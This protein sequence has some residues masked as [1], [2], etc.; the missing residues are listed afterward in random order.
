ML[1]YLHCDSEYVAGIDVEYTEPSGAVDVT[2][3]HYSIYDLGRQSITHCLA[4]ENYYLS[5]PG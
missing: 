1:Y 5:S 2:Q 4:L 3:C